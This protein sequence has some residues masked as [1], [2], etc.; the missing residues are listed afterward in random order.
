MFYRLKW[1]RNEMTSVEHCMAGTA[2]ARSKPVT[3]FF[4]IFTKK[5][6]FQFCYP[7][8]ATLKAVLFGGKW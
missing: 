4:G 2:E 7:I 6:H 1:R 5:N 8:P 3:L